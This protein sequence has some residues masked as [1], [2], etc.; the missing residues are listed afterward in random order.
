MPIGKHMTK[1]ILGVV[2]A[3]LLLGY[4]FP[5]GLNAVNE[6]PTY[7][8]TQ[9]EG[10]EYQVQER[11]N[12]TVTN[13]YAPGAGDNATVQLKDTQT[14]TT[15][16]KTIDNGTTVQYTGL[17]GG[18]VNVTVNDITSASPNTIGLEYQV[19]QGFAWDDSSQTIFSTLGIF[20]VIVPL[21]VLAKLTM[22]A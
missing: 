13:S 14:G 11:L 4:V 9:D 5:V 21:I 2:I 18:Y 10:T 7:N 17:E 19:E 20:L 16:S 1:V 3:G 22:A 12:S 15:V 6:D 8:L